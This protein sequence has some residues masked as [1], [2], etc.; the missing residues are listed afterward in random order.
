MWSINKH[1]KAET[2]LW[3]VI[4]LLPMAIAVLVWLGVS[5]WAWLAMDKCLDAGGQYDANGSCTLEEKQ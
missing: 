3:L 5:A 4:A 1:F 2:T